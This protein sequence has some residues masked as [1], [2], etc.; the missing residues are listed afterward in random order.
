MP[1]QKNGITFLWKNYFFQN[2]SY[3]KTDRSHKAA[4]CNA[5]LSG[6]MAIQREM[7]AR[8]TRGG[9]IVQMRSDEELREHVLANSEPICGKIE[10]MVAH[11]RKC[12]YISP[13]AQTSILL[14][15]RPQE[16]IQAPSPRPPSDQLSSSPSAQQIDTVA[17]RFQVSPSTNPRPVKRTRSLH[18]LAQG[19]IKHLVRSLAPSQ[20]QEEFSADLCKLFIS[21]N[22]AWYAAE[23]PSLHRFVHKWVGSEVVVQDR[24]I[25]SG[26]VLDNEVKKVEEALAKKVRGK[27]ATGQ[28]DGW[29]NVAKSS[30]IS[31][32]MSVEN[33][34]YLIQTHDVTREAKTGEQLLK[35]VLE[36]K[37][38]ME[39]KYG[40]VLIGWCTD[41]GP[42]GKKM[43]RLLQDLFSWLIVILCWAHQIN[44]VVGD[45]LV[46]RC[47]VT[48][49][50]NRALEVIK[51]F[52]NHGTALALL[53]TEQALTFQ[54]SFWALILPAIT[55]WTAHYLAITRYLKIKPALQIC[56]ARNEYKLI[57]C[58]GTKQ[59]LQEKARV[60]QD[61]VRDEG[62][63]G[64]LQK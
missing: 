22:T 39:E 41:N 7:D 16:Q 50:I 37:K 13:D 60:I 55:R 28:C 61:Y 24:R 47:T 44:L 58:A 21:T 29:K 25:L 1:T 3:Y 23:N 11:A 12:Y 38:L 9:E 2:G 52:N 46:I 4:W 48:E 31:T 18:S 54:G 8:R 36:D 26:R 32:M 6:H 64:R 30:V 20:L 33:E 59:D 10:R 35:H 15:F 5:C 43:R 51:W 45:F 49:D 53:Q 62:L 34:Q 17:T 40:V 27:E 63:W 56:W 42:D 14:A 57:T 19:G